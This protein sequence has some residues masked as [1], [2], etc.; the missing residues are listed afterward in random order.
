MPTI[1]YG[2]QIIQPNYQPDLVDTDL[3][4]KVL[5]AKQM[6]YDT[7]FKNLSDLKSK[8]LNIRFLNKKSQSEVDRMN[9]DID[10]S[11]KGD[12]GDLSNPENLRK[13]YGAFERFTKDTRLINR[14]RQDAKYQQ[15]LVTVEQK[16]TAKDPKKAGFHNV[17]YANYL[18][19]L[20]DYINA[21]L[22]SVASEG[23]TVKP[24]TDYV[25]YSK[26]ITEAMKAVPIKKFSET[27]LKNGYLETK[28]YEGRD[29]DEVRRVIN[30][31]MSGKAA[32]QVREEAEYAFRNSIGNP[33]IEDSLYNDHVNY[34]LNQQRQISDRLDRTSALL[35]TETNPEKIKVLAEEKAY[36]ESSLSDVKM[37]LKDRNSYFQRSADDIVD[38]MTKVIIQ[39]K[40][41]VNADAFGGYAVTRK[42]EPDRTFLEL[43]KLRQRQQ[44]FSANMKFKYNKLAVDSDFKERELNMRQSGNSEDSGTSEGGLDANS[45]TGAGYTPPTGYSFISNSNPEH[46]DF[47]SV[48]SNIEAT[49]AKLYAQQSNFLR[50]G[51]THGNRLISGEEA[52]LEL[53]IKP[54]ILDNSPYH[55]GSPYLRAYKVALDELAVKRP[56]L[57]ELTNAGRPKDNDT[58]N[59]LKEANR[60]ITDRVEQMINN[61]RTREEAQYANHLQDVKANLQ[62]VQ[63]FT[64]RANESGD[65]KNFIES[66]PMIARYG[67]TV[68]NFDV[69][70]NASKD[71]K[72]KA[73]S[74]LMQFKSSFENAFNT[75]YSFYNDASVQINEREWNKVYNDPNRVRDFEVDDVSQVM[76]NDNGKIRVSFKQSA[77]D[78]GNDE[79]RNAGPL[80]SDDKY[81][82]V[83]DGG[84]VKKIPVS[85]IKS[86]GFLE[87]TDPKYNKFNWSNQMGLAVSAKPQKRWD[88]SADGQS[89][90]FEIRKNT[91]TDK[92][93]VSF[94]GGAFNSTNISNPDAVINFARQEIAKR[95]YN[96]LV[97][98]TR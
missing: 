12:M 43:Q 28:N 50:D 23:L 17:N 20:G 25:D 31:M 21:D 73:A 2:Y 40:V 63:D 16:R 86:K 7:A 65:P 62:S 39:D 46:I 24:Y 35:N 14:Y 6:Q 18:A 27:T 94:N 37:S 15:E 33:A 59:R 61:P 5:M 8:A 22:D 98:A 88:I 42:V 30:D 87:Y 92:I 76:V 79:G 83:I 36:L 48:V 55:G 51:F 11:F 82:T 80:S 66:S 9:E 90:F 57:Y 1:G 97:T 44:E 72:Q 4:A 85:E 47:G 70:K 29:P 53:L 58:W 19:R 75:P 56:D 54:D 78:P 38:D 3:V 81:F 93:E 34:N 49:T 68:Y 77:F 71:V 67:N 60:L 89:V 69:P 41:K 96:E 74:Q 10:N 45:N 26:D 95:N 84:K 52:G 91:V 64:K 13:Y 32:S